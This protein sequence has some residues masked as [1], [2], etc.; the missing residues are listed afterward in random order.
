MGLSGDDG[1]RTPDSSVTG[2]VA[3]VRSGPGETHRPRAASAAPLLPRRRGDCP[4]PWNRAGRTGRTRGL[5][6][7]HDDDLRRRAARA[8]PAPRRPLLRDAIAAD[9]EA[10][11]GRAH[12]ERFGSDPAL[13]VKLLH[14]G[15][16]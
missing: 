2:R 13:L 11:L 15:E 4:L 12:T 3:C 6:G 8:Q 16:R 14:A 9:P 10:F 7:L 5:G 1:T